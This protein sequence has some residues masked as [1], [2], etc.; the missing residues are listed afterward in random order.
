VQGLAAIEAFNESVSP[1]LYGFGIAAIVAETLYMVRS[2]SG[3]DVASRT[4][5]VKC[6]IL[7]FGAE[8]IFQATAMLALQTWVY[9]HR[10]F[11]LGLHWWVWL[12]C[13]V[14]NDTMFYVSHRLQ[15]RCRL[16]WAIH[17]VHHS[18]KHY[19]LTTGIRGSVLG[20]LAA[21][22]FYVWIPILGIHPLVVLIVD[23][24]FKFYG[25][26]YHTEFIQKLGWLDR[27]LVTPSNHRVHHAT[28]P[29]YLDRNYGGFF[30]L[31]DRVLGTFEPEVEACR[32]GLVKDW[33]G[34]GLWD[35]QVHEFRDLWRDVRSASTWS[36]KIRHVFK[37]P[38]WQPEQ[39]PPG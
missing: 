24:V 1:A 32:Y 4:L 27:F 14:V 35:C 19:D 6:G 33:H 30:I 8:G 7:A 37:P 22:P 26:A 17:V 20:W 2:H 9:Q 15:H 39:R 31:Y 34:Y 29:H 5:G 10:L 23:K 21:F 11:D 3:R 36:Q 12:L 28:N 18:P 13:F 25:L 38:G 16:L